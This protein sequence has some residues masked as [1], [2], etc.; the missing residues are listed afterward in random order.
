[1]ILRIADLPFYDES[2]IL[3]NYSRQLM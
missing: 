1:M 2:I 3:Y